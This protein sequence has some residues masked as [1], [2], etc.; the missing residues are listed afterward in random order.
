VAAALIASQK[1]VE[2]HLARVYRKRGIRS[3]A[4]LG[5]R[6]STPPDDRQT[7]APA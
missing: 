1:T 6:M 7:P 3:R 2:A 5:A 4:D